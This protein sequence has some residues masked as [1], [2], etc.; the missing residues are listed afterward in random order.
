M[1]TTTHNE[2]LERTLSRQ[3]GERLLAEKLKPILDLSWTFVESIAKNLFDAIDF[4][5][6]LVDSQITLVKKSDGGKSP[7]LYWLVDKE[8]PTETFFISDV[9]LDIV[10]NEIHVS[11]PRGTHLFTYSTLTNALVLEDDKLSGV[12]WLTS[13]I[14][15]LFK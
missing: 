10:V 6:K 3:A 11:T 9:L 14:D 4:K 1:R 12:D 13:I 5:S 2:Y 8:Y 15:W 7:G